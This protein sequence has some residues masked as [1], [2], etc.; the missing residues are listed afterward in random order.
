M[1]SQISSGR[2]YIWP[3]FARRHPPKSITAVSIDLQINLATA[4]SYHTINMHS[5]LFTAEGIYNS[6]LNERQSVHDQ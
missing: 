4:D 2:G 6:K 3:L 5:H 1:P